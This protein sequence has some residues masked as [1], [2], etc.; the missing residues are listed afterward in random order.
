MW[1]SSYERKLSICF[2]L[3]ELIFIEFL[4]VNSRFFGIYSCRVNFGFYCSVFVVWTYIWRNDIWDLHWLKVLIQYNRGIRWFFLFVDNSNRVQNLPWGAMTLKG[5]LTG[6][7]SL[8]L[9]VWRC[10]SVFAYAREP[11]FN[12]F[13][14]SV[15]IR[16]ISILSLRL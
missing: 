7:S 11:I 13:I 2:G 14:F 10:L 15:I 9:G 5:T 3:S 4:S 1:L 8:F 16:V 12:I 6:R